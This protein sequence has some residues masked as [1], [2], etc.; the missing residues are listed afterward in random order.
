MSQKNTIEFSKILLIKENKNH[1]KEISKNNNFEIEFNKSKTIL[2]NYKSSSLDIIDKKIFNFKDFL[3]NNLNIQIQSNIEDKIYI[4]NNK[5]NKINTNEKIFSNNI[6]FKL[7]QD[8]HSG[9]PIVIDDDIQ[10]SNSNEK[11]SISINNNI[12][13]KEKESFSNMMPFNIN[14]NIFF[15]ENMNNTNTNNNGNSSTINNN[16]KSYSSNNNNLFIVKTPK[17]SKIGKNTKI[18]QN[19][20]NFLKNKRNSN[21]SNNTNSDK[22]EKIKKVKIKKEDLFN[23][24][25]SLYNQLKNNSNN[26]IKNINQLIIIQNKIKNV[27]K[28][29]IIVDNKNLCDIFLLNG[30]IKKIFS[31]TNNSLYNKEKDIN[32]QLTIIKDIFN[33]NIINLGISITD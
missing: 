29:T 8:F 13:N 4:K 1:E 9:S 19:S 27:D 33:K 6:R 2:N 5:E 7:F 21:K 26:N 30:K 20:E 25:M 23:Q 17:K 18:S 3:I 24:I 12:D 32:P 16:D 15:E 14:N 11:N 28:Y 22:K 31:Y 10:K